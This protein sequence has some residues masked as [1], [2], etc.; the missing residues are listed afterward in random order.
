MK[1]IKVAGKK[2]ITVSGK[3]GNMNKFMYG[4]TKSTGRKR[5]G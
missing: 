4:R 5:K 3:Q 2:S 1:Y